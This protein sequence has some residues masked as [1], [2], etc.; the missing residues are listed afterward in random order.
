MSFWGSKVRDIKL[1]FHNITSK[2]PLCNGSQIWTK[3]ETDAL[4]WKRHKWDTLRPLFYPT[5]DCNRNVNIC[6]TL[7]VDST[8]KYMKNHKDRLLEM[9]IQKSSSKANHVEAGYRMKQTKMERPRTL[10]PLEK[11]GSRFALP[12]YVC[13][14]GDDDDVGDDNLHFI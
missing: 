4:N 6:S 14:G 5:V 10:W 1:R 13:G 8:S 9:N 7:K 2:A 11:P 12:S 3:N